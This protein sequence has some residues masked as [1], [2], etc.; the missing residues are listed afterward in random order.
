M[1]FISALMYI[2]CIILCRFIVINLPKKNLTNIFVTCSRLLGLFQ[3][4][5]SL[6]RKLSPTIDEIPD[7][8]LQLISRVNV[9][10]R[11]A[12]F[13]NT[14]CNIVETHTYMHT[15]LRNHGQ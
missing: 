6:I 2:I 3:R 4:T 14:V 7:W 12:I 13:Q 8:M 9:E 1:S 10:Y 5:K 15:S 11:F